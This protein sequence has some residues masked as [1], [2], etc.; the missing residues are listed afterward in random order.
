M[1]TAID[2]SLDY[3][4]DAIK[5]IKTDL[6][7]ANEKKENFFNLT[8]EASKIQSQ[9]NSSSLKLKNLIKKT[10]KTLKELTEEMNENNK[11][12]NTNENT[13]EKVKIKALK[14]ELKIL[15]EHLHSLRQVRP[16]TRSFFCRMFLGRVN[17]KIWNPEQ[18]DRL[19]DEYNKFKGRTTFIF[20]LFPLIVLFTHYNL[21]NNWKDTH[22]LN[23]FHQ[24]WMLY[25]YISSALRENILLVNNSNI[26]TWWIVHHYIAAFGTIIAITWPPTEVYYKYVPIFTYFLIYQGFVQII[27]IW[28]QHTRD[29]AKRAIGSINRV[30]V[31][32]TETITEFPKELLIL[33]PFLYTSHIWQLFISYLLYNEFFFEI[34]DIN[35]HW[36]EYTQEV[37]IFI[38]ATV[39][40]LLFIGN[41]YTTTIILLQKA[42]KSRSNDKNGKKKMVDKSN[43]LIER[44]R[45]LSNSSNNSLSANN[46]NAM[47][48]SP[49]PPIQTQYTKVNNNNKKDL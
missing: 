46:L 1:D 37:Q 39:F 38:I 7:V 23:I 11:K 25:Y 32:F 48:R 22:W 47:S 19:R 14:D 8:N 41:M 2:H 33:V 44:A 5:D 31:T 20:I 16:E 21:R 28:Y 30:D 34:F 4:I 42:G 49:T 6:N 18:K 27:Q 45:R 24:L 40:L 13:N 10:K 9:I 17:L 36:T 26:K 29:Y 12:N 43:S 15:E 35:L 3:V